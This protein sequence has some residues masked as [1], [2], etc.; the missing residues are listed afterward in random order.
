MELFNRSHC[1]LR[2]KTHF[3]NFAGICSA[4]SVARYIHILGY[5]LNLLFFPV[6]V[7]LVNFAILYQLELVVFSFFN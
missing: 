4:I 6:L 2:E 1:T 3:L 7:V 5:S